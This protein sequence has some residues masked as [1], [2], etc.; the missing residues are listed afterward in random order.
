MALTGLPD[1]GAPLLAG[2]VRYPYG[3]GSFT[4]LPDQLNVATRPDGTPDLLV[5]LVRGAVPSL[6]PDPHGVIDIRLTPDYRLDEA[7]A[8]ARQHRPGATVRPFTVSAG[9][10]R[11]QPATSGVPVPESLTVPVPLTFDGLDRIRFT[12]TVPMDAAVF[13]QGLLTG[14][15][16][17]LRA[18]AE[19]E[20]PGVAPRLP[21]TVSFNPHA[22]LSAI[23]GGDPGIV[24][25]GDRVGGAA[26]P[27]GGGGP[28][29]RDDLLT[30]LT[31]RLA[32]LPV[33]VDGDPGVDPG[34]LAATLVDW[35][36]ARYALPAPAPVAGSRTYLSLP[37]EVPSG[38][39]TW[40]L[41]QPL[42]TA[43][44]LVLDLDP[45]T[46]ARAFVLA[47]GV[48]AL[49]TR[50]VV[51]VLQTG[52]LSVA[53][54]ANLPAV[55]LGVLE[56]GVELVA[57]PRPPVRPQQVSAHTQLDPPADTAPMRLRLSPA[58]PPEFISV[59]YAVMPDGGNEPLRGP[60]V[61]RHGDTVRL[62]VTDFPL[63]FLPVRADPA[64]LALSSVH[65][66][67]QPGDPT[68]PAQ[69]A[70]LDGAQ[71]AVAFT[72]PVTAVGGV[73]TIEFRPRDGS[74]AVQLGP[75]DAAPQILT[76][77]SLP[78][79][80]PQQVT[81]TGVFFRPDDLVAIDLLT[82]GRPEDPAW[83]STILLTADR[84]TRIWRYAAESPFHAGYRWR[85]YRS[86]PPPDPWS[87]VY[88]A[89]APLTVQA[90][91]ASPAPAATIPAPSDPF[92]PDPDL[93]GPRA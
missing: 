72:Q 47:H 8:L 43:R 22:L 15:T 36:R 45:V 90:E 38:H 26:E 40:D 59:A 4:V 39:V 70:D 27:V 12:A 48:D 19:L 68:L 11:L 28:V 2:A 78:G 64:V 91:P 76:L 84:P 51:P 21:A 58:E 35:V 77:A 57:P 56:L 16:L 49:V 7:L 82:E 87:D 10:L 85:R 89:S 53:V 1:F 18:H 30:L 23:G 25:G 69:E 88:P 65:V 60:A 33:H 42:P 67:F 5:T 52:Q 79:Y 17:G 29:A 92:L 24:G 14:G 50:R 41:R 61:P 93:G 63:T 81:V 34:L 75:L 83:I 20:Y 44:S 46:S 86:T 73:L 32:E 80:G 3:S 55:R 66:R 37:A 13:V 6:P 62:S 31:T 54:T 9:F 74:P 71:T